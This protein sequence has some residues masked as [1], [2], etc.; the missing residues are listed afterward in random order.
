M[1]NEGRVGSWC[2]RPTDQIPVPSKSFLMGLP[3]RCTVR[4]AEDGRAGC[5]Q[6]VESLLFIQ[7]WM[8]MGNVLKKGRI[9]VLVAET[10]S[11]SLAIISVHIVG[12]I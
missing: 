7:K 10:A 5:V 3:T 6:D 11:H 12:F 9:K 4:P 8:V 2:V 1:K